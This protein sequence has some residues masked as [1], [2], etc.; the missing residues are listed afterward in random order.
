M[1]DDDLLQIDES[2]DIDDNI[3][4]S[5][6]ITDNDET[7]SN[8][9]SKKR[10]MCKRL[11]SEQ[12]SSYIKRTPAQ[13]GGSRRVEIIA[14]ELFPRFLDKN[15]SRKKLNY[16]EKRKLNR[17]LYA[18]SIWQIDKSCNSVRSKTCTGFAD[19]GDI[20]HEC[21][22]MRSD[23]R[24]RT[25]IIKKVPLPENVKFTP[26]FY[27]E[28]NALKK[29]LKNNH[30]RDV[31]NLL[32]NDSDCNDNSKIWIALADKALQGVFNDKPIF[33]GLC[34]VMNDAAERKIKNKGKQNIKYSEE[35]TNFLV[36]LGGFSTRALDLFWQNLEG[37]CIQSIRYL[38]R[39]GEDCLTNPDLC[40]ENVARFKRLIDTIKY[41]GPIA[42]ITDNTKL[43]LCLRYSP[44]LGCIVGSTLPND[45]TKVNVYGDIPKIINN[46]KNQMAIAKDVRAYILQVPSPKF[47]PVVIALIPNNLKDTADDISML[48]RKLIQEIA[49]RLQ[50]YILS[51]GSDGAIVE[52]QAQEKI[53][54]IQTPEQLSIHDDNLNIHFSCPI[55]NNVGPIIRVQDPKHV[56]KT[57]RNA[58][59][60][61]ARLLTFGNSSA[62][63]SHFLNLIGRYDSILYRND[64]IKLDRQDDAAAYRTFCSSN[65]RQ[66]LTA[67]YKIQPEMDGFFI[68]LF[69]IGEIVDSYLNRDVTLIERIRM[70]MTGFFFL[71]LWKFHIKTLAQKYPDFININQNFLADQTF[72][73]LISLC[74]SMVLLVKAHR[75]YYPQI[76]LIPWMH[77]SEPCEHFFGVAR[78]INSDFSFAEIIQMLPKIS[79]YTKALRNKKLNFEKGKSVREGYNFDYNSGSL[80][81][82]SMQKLRFWPSD[83]QIS[84][85][86][87]HSHHLAKELAE[88]LGMIQPS[89][90]LI[91][92][93]TPTTF[94]DVN[95]DE[96]LRDNDEYE[97]SDDCEADLSTAINKASSELQKLN[98]QLGET[99]E[100]EGIFNDG[101][102]QI[103]LL[104]KTID[105]SILNSGDSVNIEFKYFVDDD[106]NFESLINQRRL[107]EA[108]CSKP[109]ERRFK[110]VGSNL[111]SSNNIS[112]QPNK[113]SHFVAYFTKNENPEQRFVT[114]REK[115]W[116]DYRK[117]LA[118]T[119]A[120]LHMEEFEK[121][122]KKKMINK[123]K[124][125]I[126]TIQIPN[127][128][129]ANIT[130]EF[131]LVKGHY[132][133][134]RY[135]DKMCVGRVISI[136]FD[137]YGKHCYADEPVETINDISYISLH[138]YIPVHNVFSDLVKEG[139]NI[140]THHIPSNIVYHISETK[141][142]IDGNILKL[143]G[144]EKKY[145]DEYFGRDDIIEKIMKH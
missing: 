23:K 75:G 95:D 50:L 100:N 65:L 52:F 82:L 8:Q 70:A 77:G 93:N 98:E 34:E 121:S 29:H 4:I 141:V 102:S 97:I 122:R 145:Y 76:P 80:D 67:D 18:E 105:M 47:P 110:P 60:S 92:S 35:F 45:Q 86:F 36:I 54:A 16:E 106:L 33:V 31:W 30:L 48:H 10:Q 27:W 87:H 61:G 44:Q 107:H 2:S 68:Y 22:H 6:L 9:H 26:K 125:H 63:Y 139:C 124:A 57:A 53:L 79:Q 113:A 119:L 111:S 109:L 72:S 140:L 112:I 108:Y 7:N 144:D 66:C 28:D 131:P 38:R 39:N 12:I 56:K 58:L 129:D 11:Q 25:N 103:Q 120:Q 85:T 37:R 83:E 51:I 117:N 71:H 15:F 115:R 5:T 133:F 135:G 24:L 101:Y 91:N 90:L 137:A 32:N 128:E 41:S 132:V 134:V 42:A 40:Y 96:N 17:V 14:C 127:I 3:L 123:R 21:H 73:I 62:R 136:Y 49:P 84:Q 13:F 55:F 118:L 94:I 104:D 99:H 143:K 114:Q 19:C 43:K 81:E 64:V 126:S 20:C 142:L 89:T 1:D 69:V 46:I 74:Q 116:K 78:Q 88:F 59:M 130:R 138:V